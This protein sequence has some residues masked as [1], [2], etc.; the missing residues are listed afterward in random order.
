M[1]KLILDAM[2]SDLGAKAAV[3]GAALFHKAHPA[4]EL[5]LVGKAE[6]LKD[7][8][9]AKIIDARSVVPMNAGALEVLRLKDSSMVQAIN[10]VASEKADAV[11]SAGS[12]GAFLS[13]STLILKKIPGVERPALVTSFPN[14]ESGNYVTVLDMGAS[15]ANTPAEMAHFGFMGTLYSRFVNGLEKPRVA[16]LSNGAEEGKGSPEGKEAYALLKNDKKVNFV[17]NIEASQIMMGS[18]DVVVT[19]GY[20][21]NVLLKSTEGT[22]KAFGKLLKKA[23]KRNLGSKIGYLLSKKGIAQ[24]KDVFDPRKTGGA[25]LI[26]V[27]AVVVKAH[28]NSDGEAY[29]HALELAYR[30]S[31]KQVVKTIQE[32]LQNAA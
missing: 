7:A 20:S 15:N 29:Y 31:E 22:A 24:M 18:A 4:C 30:L 3:E 6:E 26:G 9:F 16:L 2:G 13:A 1:S 23:F 14:L 25:L 11:V 28:G 17:G 12:T 10:A 27:N 19:D 8:S 21:G 5:V 32:G